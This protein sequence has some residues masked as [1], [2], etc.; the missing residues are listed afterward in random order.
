MISS[1][2]SEKFCD[3]NHFDKAVPGYKIALEISGLDHNITQIPIQ[4]K[5]QTQKRQIIWFNLPYSANLKTNVGKVFMRIGD[6]YFL[7]LH[8]Y[9]KLFNRNNIKLSY[10]CMPGMNNVIQKHNSKIMNN[11]AP[12]TIK[13]RNFRRETGSHM[14]GNCLSDCLIQK[15]LLIQLLIN[16]TMVLLKILLK[17]LTITINFLLEI[18][19]VKR[20]LNCF[21]MYGNWKRKL[22]IVLSIFILLWN[23]RYMFEDL[24][25]DL[26]VLPNKRDELVSKCRHGN[27]FTL[28]C[29]RD[30]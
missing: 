9:Y 23:Q 12:C 17:N 4:S 15:H 1:Q 3:K 6:E 20:T 14:N 10:S 22:L 26:N 13:T 29:L 7:H 27:K 16:I 19:L 25:V 24:I 11:V 8:K 18:N 2:I 5:C 30:R 28:N 21:S